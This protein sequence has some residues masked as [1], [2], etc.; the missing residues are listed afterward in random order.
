MNDW[1]SARPKIESFRIGP[2]YTRTWSPILAV[3]A[4]H[5]PKA[6]PFLADGVLSGA[7]KWEGARAEEGEDGETALSPPEGGVWVVAELKQEGPLYGM[8]I[9][10]GGPGNNI[11]AYE[12]H[13]S[14]DGSQY[15]RMGGA[16][17]LPDEAQSHR[18]M[19]PEPV[20]ARFL[21]VTIPSGEWH[22]EYPEIREIEAFTDQYRPAPDEPQDGVGFI[23]IRRDN[24]G[25]SRERSPH[26]EQGFPY[27]RGEGEGESRYGWTEDGE[28]EG[29]AE[30]PL[31]SFAYHYD[32]VRFHYDGLSKDKLYT[33]YVSY[34]QNAGGGRRQNLTADGFLLHGDAP[35]P[36]KAEPP[37]VFAVPQ[38]AVQDGELTIAANRLA[39]PN[40]VVSEISLY[41]SARASGAA[42]SAARQRAKA[43]RALSP[44][45]IDGRLDDWSLLRALREGGADEPSFW[46]EWD[47]SALYVAAEIPARLLP[48]TPSLQDAFDL[49]L[50]ARV[51]DAE[52]APSLSV[53]RPGDVHIRVLRVGGNAAARY[54]RHETEGGEPPGPARIPGVELA[55]RTEDGVHTIEMALP[56]GDALPEWEPAVD[57]EI[58]FNCILSLSGRGSWAL[59]AKRPHDPP[60]RWLRC[61]LLG[62]IRAEARFGSAPSDFQ[63]PPPAEPF[64]FFA[65]GS[66]WAMVYDPDANR[67]PSVSETVSAELSGE[68][69]GETL[70]AELREGRLVSDEEGGA[71][72]EP[73]ADS[74]RFF[75]RIETRFALEPLNDPDRM[76]A[77][78]GETLTARYEDRFAHPDGGGA[79]ASARASAISGADGQIDALPAGR[80]TAGDT[81]RIQAADADA[82]GLKEGGR[83]VS[84]STEGLTE[85]RDVET[86]LLLPPAEEAGRFEAA[87][88]TVYSAEP[89][90]GDGV[91][92]IVGGQSA[93]VVYADRVRASGETNVRV[94]ASTQAASG[95]T[96]RLR[97]RL[98]GGSFEGFGAGGAVFR[99]GTPLIVRVED[100][101]LNR[102]GAETETAVVEASGE[103]LGDALTIALRETLPDSGVFEG[104][105]PTRHDSEARANEAIEAAGGE[106]VRFRH[107][108]A[109]QATGEPQVRVETAAAVETGGDARLAVVREDYAAQLERFNAGDMV[110]FRLEE[111]D[112]IGPQTFITAVSA[113]TGDRERVLLRRSA[114][115]S[116]LYFGAVPTA[117][118]AEAVSDGL[119]QTVGNDTVEGRYTDALRAS[120]ETDFAV[121][122][123][124]RANVG[125]DGSLRTLDAAGG[126]ETDRFRAGESI[127]IEVRD[128]DLNASEEAIETAS[129]DAREDFLGDSVT[130]TL[131]ETTGNSGLFRGEL[132]TAYA[133]SAAEDNILQALGQSYVTIAYID[134]LA[135]SGEAQAARTASLYAAIGD[136]GTVA[137]LTL[138]GERRIGNLRPNGIALIRVEDADLNADPKFEESAAATAEGNLLGDRT[139]LELR[140]TGQDTG[141]FEARLATELADAANPN[142]L[143]LQTAQHETVTITYVDALNDAGEPNAPT[144]AAA[145]IAGSS[146][147]RIVI[148]AEDGSEIGAFTAGDWLYISAQ[149]LLLAADPT[150]RPVA[151]LAASESGDRA[152]AVLEPA[153]GADGVFWGRVA[154]RYS[155]LPNDDNTLDI[156]GGETVTASYAPEGLFGGLI[157]DSAIARR[158]RLGRLSAALPDGSALEE[159]TPGETA[160]LTVR[161]ADRNADPLSAEAVS[162]RAFAQ[163]GGEPLEIRL[164]ETAPDSGAFQGELPTAFGQEAPPGSLG[165][166]GGE[167]IALVY[168]DPLTDTGEAGVE[169]GATVRVR[170]VGFAPYAE[171][172]AVVDGNSNLWDLNRVMSSPDEEIR[173]WSQWTREALYFFIQVKDDRLAVEDVTRWHIGSDAVELHIDTFPGGLEG[174]RRGSSNLPA[175]LAGS[176]GV[177]GRVFWLCPL[178][179]GFT[180]G[181]PYIGQALPAQVYN[182]SDRDFGVE[183][184]AE[185]S[186]GYYTLEARLPYHTA[187][188]GF[189]PFASEK[190]RRVGFNFLLYRSDAPRVWWAG[191]LRSP[192]SAGVLYLDG[193]P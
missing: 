47:E 90:P 103:A 139:L 119:L 128:D 66:L 144:R 187:L 159:L 84:V 15:R 62:S 6:A 157:T 134:A 149:D 14:R 95:D 21:R 191:P 82:Y 104:V 116:D 133:S 79:E 35:I 31:R 33:V 179:G 120:G 2:V 176:G 85:D 141:V 161:D 88:P 102:D 151:L 7:S 98:P 64:P 25:R 147:G 160:V 69:S 51:D 83:E 114:A 165:L 12:A 117:Y 170:K 121:S 154:T 148:A 96:A 185:A 100:A 17:D 55:S 126:A 131:R 113:S 167:T 28:I 130:L 172:S 41:E 42:E 60:V 9:A 61:L 189:D 53:Y 118:G 178:G 52:H 54:V 40:A 3:S 46:A 105:A 22:G 132:R 108:D 30:E 10:S 177:S 107:L 4:S 77:R 150:V 89:V 152:R 80:F 11:K 158:G 153:P 56:K 145:V 93:A 19:F 192:S 91:L 70:T 156:R 127:V 94:A 57:R 136:R 181:R 166:A 143:L 97:I 129:V 115:S 180:G 99:A 123:S 125:N 5:N 186:D 68:L 44:P 163:E 73:S 81:L 193:S 1:Y 59:S 8:R 78:G 67:D 76:T 48:E 183:I 182:I 23:Q 188:P 135:A 74:E 39:G 146:P 38:A 168:V 101:D 13:A 112:D 174:G 27:D 110:Y 175:H 20:T 86:L 65:G 173:V 142:D 71:R 24:C 50:D 169:I 32:S 26:L 92:Q 34:L 162:A 49:F 109:L 75:A 155:L 45:A 184:G 164:T 140:E 111:P 72:L 18:L 36:S 58:G 87:L 138:D 16:S 37:R 171:R 124:A 190:R 122:A 63:G 29:E 106:T 137:A 43:V